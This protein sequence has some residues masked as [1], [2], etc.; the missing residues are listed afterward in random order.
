MSALLTMEWTE[1]TETA[2]TPTITARNVALFFA[3]PFVGLLYALAMPL[4]GIGALLWVAAKALARILPATR[5][6]ALT[7]AA[8]FIGLAFIAALPI[9]GVVGLAS[10][11]AASIKS[12]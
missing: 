11:A 8:P 10:A 4:V 6:I 9:L 7:L 1:S 3:A 5:A 2:A 12:R